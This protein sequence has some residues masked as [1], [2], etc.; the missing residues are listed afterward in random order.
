MSPAETSGTAG[1]RDSGVSAIVATVL[2]A[3]ARPGNQLRALLSRPGILEQPA[4]CDPLSARLARDSGYEAVAMAGHAIGAHRAMTRAP[5][6]DDIEQAARGVTRACGIPVL[7]AADAEWGDGGQVR[8]VVGRL[9][10]AGVAAIQLSSPHVLDPAPASLAAEHRRA[11]AGLL[12]RVESARAARE[13]ALIMARCDVLPAFGYEEALDRAAALLA[14][15]ADALLVHG[16]D[17]EL[18][19]LPQDLPG[20]TLIYAAP[21]EAGCMRSVF[22]AQLLEQW[23]YSAVSNQYHR[24]YCARIQRPARDEAF[25]AVAARHG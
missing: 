3:T 21:P 20:A 25:P 18:R 19:R 13:H 15:G 14:A 2:P 23:G 5:S 8:V 4:I 1:H 22:P 9:E 6:F 11:Q 16:G 7:L 24:C 10:A 17:D 12:R